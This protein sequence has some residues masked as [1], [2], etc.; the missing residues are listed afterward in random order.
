MGTTNY[1]MKQE[2][3][4]RLLKEAQRDPLFKKEI[5]SFIKATTRVYKLE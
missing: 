4:I 5:N 3:F 2:E 1:K